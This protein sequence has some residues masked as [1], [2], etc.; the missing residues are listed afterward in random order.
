M[1][2]ILNFL[3][4]TPILI[5]ILAVVITAL[6]TLLPLP[7]GVPGQYWGRCLL[8]V[9]MCGTM[10]FFLYLISGEK[11]LEKGNNQ[12]GYV[13][14]HLL[15]FL[16]LALLQGL[17]GVWTNLRSAPVSPG[18]PMRALAVVCMFFFACMFEEFCFRAVLNDAIVYQFRNSKGV[19]ALSAVVTCLVFGAIHMLGSPLETAAHWLQAA[20]KTLQC[21]CMGFALLVLYWK[22]R[23]VWAC[24]IAHALFDL[25]ADLSMVFVVGSGVGGAGSYVKEGAEGTYGSIVLAVNIA[26]SA[27]FAWIV[28]R[29]VGRT[30]DFEDMRKNW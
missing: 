10:L 15:P 23:N 12:T 28:W 1:T 24:G 9:L 27:L 25:L 20:L 22:T 19:F 7:E 16:I 17:L 2:K 11:T 3:K 29:K 26:I 8:R 4:K 13:I 5:A 18:L 30:I 21:A 14:R 6:T